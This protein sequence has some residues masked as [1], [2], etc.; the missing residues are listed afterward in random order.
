MW[1]LAVGRGKLYPRDMAPLLGRLQWIA[2]P[3]TAASP[4]LAGACR[5]MHAPSAIFT[6][7]LARATATSLL[8][9]F[10]SHT[11]HAKS[12]A[13]RT[14][15]FA[16]TAPYGIRFRVGVVIP[17]GQYCHEVCP[18]W[19]KNL[20]QAELFASYPAVRLAAYRRHAAVN[21]GLDNDAA[22]AQCLSMQAITSCL[23][24]QRILRRIFWLRAW[25]N[26]D[27]AFFFGRPLL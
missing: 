2:R 20:Q 11:V 1:I 26:T 24:Q 12:L 6:R 14:T 3:V 5:S 10:P 16:D 22:R 8:F 21:I 7:N 17:I 9:S 23:V 19:I 18:K 15:M 13:R 25:A 27:L 4:F